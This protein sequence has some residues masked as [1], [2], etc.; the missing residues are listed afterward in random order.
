MADSRLP[1]ILAITGASGAVYGL[2]LAR[3]LLGSDISVHLLVSD[4][5]RV[6]I[7]QETRR[8]PEDWIG[9]LGKFGNLTVHRNDDFTAPIASGSFLAAGM[10]IAPCSMSSLSGVAAGVSNTL[11]KRAAD[12]CL[13]E[14]RQLVLLTR[15]TP[16]SLIHIENMRTVSLAGGII[17]P[18]VPAFYTHPQSI[19]DLVDQTLFRVLDLFDLPN[20][21]AH[22]W[23]Q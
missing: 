4:P 7:E 5:A 10:V 22:R 16:L 21:A 6:V 1:I 20:P 12:I 18:P 13:K 15:E 2:R 19:H 11:I 14:R 23:K 9:E 17:M 3:L 8:S